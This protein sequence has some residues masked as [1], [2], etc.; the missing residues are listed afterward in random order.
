MH[1]VRGYYTK[2]NSG[3]GAIKSLPI[4]AAESLT[5]RL[6]AKSLNSIRME[7]QWLPKLS[8]VLGVKQDTERVSDSFVCD[9]L[10]QNVSLLVHE[11]G[12]KTD[13]VRLIMRVKSISVNIIKTLINISLQN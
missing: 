13:R 4:I 5:K 6:I 12:K 10:G 9:A 11:V 2:I 7:V 3:S 8:L 1:F